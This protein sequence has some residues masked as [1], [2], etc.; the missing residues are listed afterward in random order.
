M[1]VYP[2]HNLINLSTSRTDLT[3]YGGFFQVSAEPP[4]DPPPEPPAPY[5]GPEWYV[6]PSGSAA[7]DGSENN[8]WDIDTA[9]T[10]S[11]KVQP[12]HTVW[13]LGGRHYTLGVQVTLTGTAA[14]PITIK[15]VAGA[16]AIIDGN[17]AAETI[18]NVD[19]LTIN[20]GGH[21]ILEGFEITNSDPSRQIDDVGSNPLTARGSGLSVNAPGVKLRNLLIYDTGQSLGAWIGATDF[22]CYGCLMWNN[23]WDAPDRGHG[24]SIYTQNNT[25]IKEYRNN[26]CWGAFGGFN[27][28]AYG[29][30]ASF[31]NNVQMYDNVF[32]GQTVLVGG[33]A[34]VHD[35]VADGNV[36][37]CVCKF[38]YYDPCYGSVVTDNHFL[39]YAQF[40][41]QDT[42]LMVTGNKW[43][44]RVNRSHI[45]IA[46]VDP[47]DVPSYT[48]S[49]NTYWQR[50]DGGTQIVAHDG[51]RYYTFAE[52]QAEAGHDLD[53]TFHNRQPDATDDVVKLTVNAYDANRATL[54]IFN[55]GSAD[56][57]AV[58][59]SDFAGAGEYVR[60]R[61]AQ[62]YF[63]DIAYT[64]G[65]TATFDMRAASHSVSTP[66]GY[67]AALATTSFPTYG[68]FVLEKYTPI[69]KARSAVPF[70]RRRRR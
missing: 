51:V 31:I 44:G 7:G 20:Q 50:Q 39:S 54:T 63:G 49:A 29:S 11:S 27:M 16:R 26:I 17:R 43:Y 4:E 66:I 64:K 5:A 59:L 6:S 23:G 60:V 28:H 22:E 15:P 3:V 13:L 38:G 58:D 68:V 37:A 45:T 1:I 19:I 34:D 67:T 35:M 36:F 33:S 30:S 40:L 70:I 62:N 48:F 69:Q 14:H 47:A 8:P 61:N 18:K 24:H 52:W 57:V 2:F 56:S 65:G 42:A 9:L 55:W 41:E 32:I 12:G 21:L 10:A 53:G 25:T 46:D